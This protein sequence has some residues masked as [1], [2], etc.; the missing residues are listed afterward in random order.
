VSACPVCSAAVE[1]RATRCDECQVALEWEG[2]QVHAK[3]PFIKPGDP[4]LFF[5][6]TRHPLPGQ[7][8]MSATL[9]DGSRFEGTPQGSLMH[10]LPKRAIACSERKMRARD[11]C[12]RAA[13][14]ALDPHISL[15]CTARLETLDVATMQYLFS[16]EPSSRKVR[17]ARGFSG[18]KETQYADLRPATPSNLVAPPG[19][20][21]V[22]ELRVQGPTLEARLNDTHVFTV[23]D[24]VLGIGRFGF[25]VEALPASTAPQRTMVAWF[26]VRQVIA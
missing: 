26:E 9:N 8:Q 6:L 18:P 25:R 19:S 3:H 24:P 5:D 14:V 23:H 22:L 12:V 7:T 2:A 1:G 16:V 4:L 21:N 13:F 10:V 20:M 15:G 17:L 11:A